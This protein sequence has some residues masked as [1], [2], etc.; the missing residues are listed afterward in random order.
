ML[1]DSSTR[2]S[3]TTGTRS[4]VVAEDEQE[5]GAAPASRCPSPPK[6]SFGDSNPS[7]DVVHDADSAANIVSASAQQRIGAGPSLGGSFAVMR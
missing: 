2:N 1:T 7:R 4:M 3:I 6:S 5:V